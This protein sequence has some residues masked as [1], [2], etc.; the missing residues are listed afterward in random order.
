MAMITLSNP[1]YI[2][3]LDAERKLAE[4]DKE[5]DKALSVGAPVEQLISMRQ[6]Y[7]EQIAALKKHYAPAAATKTQFSQQ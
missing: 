1:N 3:L 6:M 4:L 2:A 7:G 5:Y